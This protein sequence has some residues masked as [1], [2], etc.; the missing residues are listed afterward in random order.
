MKVNKQVARKDYPQHGIKKGDTYYWWQFKRSPKYYS[1]SYPKPAQLT[2]SEYLITVY[3][4][5][6]EIEEFTKAND[7]S[8][9]D[10]LKDLLARIGELRDEQQSK[11]DNMPESLQ[12]SDTANLLQE[13]Y[14]TLDEA[15]TN[16]ETIISELEEALNV[17]E[18]QMNALSEI[19]F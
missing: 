11:K 6:D 15:Y 5:Q 1:L 16:L 14:D 17:I 9:I 10:D 3:G 7:P 4:F 2:R 13:R 12:E 19:S 8:N 18:E